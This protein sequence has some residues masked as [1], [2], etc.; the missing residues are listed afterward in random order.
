M[1]AKQDV[2]EARLVSTPF[3]AGIVILRTLNDGPNIRLCTYPFK[4]CR[5]RTW[6]R[7]HKYGTVRHDDRFYI[8]YSSICGLLLWF[9]LGK[10]KRHL[11]I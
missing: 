5:A 10:P 7:S 6:M 3:R 9:L 11:L 1:L 2:Q 8:V 4:G